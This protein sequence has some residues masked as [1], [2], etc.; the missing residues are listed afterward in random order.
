M[1]VFHIILNFLAV[2]GRMYDN[3][4]LEDFLIESGVY[5][6]GTASQLLKGKQY[7]R[8]IRAH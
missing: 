4:G 8:G 7:N 3:S 6:S 5:A 1:G 2:I